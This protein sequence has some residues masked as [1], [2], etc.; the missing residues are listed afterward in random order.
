M[1]FICGILLVVLIIT[2]IGMSKKLASNNSEAERQIRELA[3]KQSSMNDSLDVRFSLIRD[4]L[5][6]DAMQTEQK[7]D[8]M[9][10]TV[11][12]SIAA[13][14]QSNMTQLDAIKKTVDEKL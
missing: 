14:Q 4:E 2:V 7:L 13:L 5:H 9:R 10:N 1:L 11:S 6:K 8:N 3:Q 12:N